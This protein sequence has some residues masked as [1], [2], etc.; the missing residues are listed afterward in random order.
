[1]RDK[2]AAFFYVLIVAVGTLLYVDYENIDLIKHPID[3]LSAL[4]DQAGSD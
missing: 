1:M 3:A 2:I 4:W